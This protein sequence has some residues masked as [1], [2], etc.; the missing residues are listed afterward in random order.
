MNIQIY[1]TAKCFDT[2]KAQRYFKERN[3]KFQF[4]DLSRF[5]MSKGE[6]QNI[7]KALGMKLKDLVNEKSKKYESSFIKY[8][9]SEEAKEEK[10]LQNQE[11]F[12]TPIVRN[13]KK[14]TL[15]YCPDE[16]KKWEEEK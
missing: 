10:L 13:G 4:V 16:W 5:G 6:Y 3:I 1:G 14:A 2:K 12:K 7:K 8:L 15:G 11:L 9:A